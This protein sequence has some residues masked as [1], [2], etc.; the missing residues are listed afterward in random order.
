VFMFEALF[1][2]L[3]WKSS[4]HMRREDPIIMQ[5][6]NFYETFKARQIKKMNIETSESYDS[7][8]LRNST[9]DDFLE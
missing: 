9:S 8:D 5:K 1:Y 2:W 6:Y 7:H 3:M 4:E